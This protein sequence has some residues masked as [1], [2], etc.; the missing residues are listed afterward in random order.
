M[1]DTEF[2]LAQAGG[3]VR[4]GTRVDIGIDAQRDRRAPTQAPR[5]TLDARELGLGF[6]VDTAHALL[7][8]ELD[9]GFALAH[10]REKRP[11]RLA[12]GGEHTHELAARD[13]VEARAKT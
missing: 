1:R 4:M 8:R 12:A 13:D 2:I 11:A 10:A 5:H 9:L 3:N 6:N 7:Q